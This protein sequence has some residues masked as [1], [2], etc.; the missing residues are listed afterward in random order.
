MVQENELVMLILGIGVLVF[1]F[2]FKE[3]IRRIF[4]WKNLLAGFYILLLAW[5]FT[6]AEGFL[7]NSFMNVLE[8]IF[9]SISTIVLAIWCFRLSIG[10][11]K[12]V[13]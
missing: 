4:G 11:K 13:K 9:Y 12:V 5:V 3:K 1:T 10:N 6:I 7:W 2:I 8:H